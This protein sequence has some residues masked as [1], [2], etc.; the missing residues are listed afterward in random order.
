MPTH[1]LLG[2]DVGIVR[3]LHVQGGEEGLRPPVAARFP[4]FP[5]VVDQQVRQF[6]GFI[7]GEPVVECVFAFAAM[8]PAIPLAVVVLVPG[9]DVEAAAPLWR[10]DV[11]C[12]AAVALVPA[13]DVPL[14]E[15]GGV[16]AG[17]LEGCG[18]RRLALRQRILVPRDAV[19]RP[20]PR[21]HGAAK[22]TAQRK[23]GDGVLEVHPQRRQVVDIRRR[24]VRIAVA[25]QGLCA[26]LV[27]DEPDD[28]GLLVLGRRLLHALGR[29]R[30]S[31]RGGRGLQE[32]ASRHRGVV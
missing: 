15:V 26:V 6:V 10:N 32:A 29:S 2:G 21:Q 3:R 25:A 20:A 28:V 30:E 19:L 7:T 31:G 1:V 12:G 14:A 11:E 24:D 4:A 18:D 8:D 17:L 22:R 27:A 16:I 9:P 5:D 13:V 23:P